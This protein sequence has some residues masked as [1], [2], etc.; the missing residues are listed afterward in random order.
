MG[1][2]N[3]KNV[4]GLFCKLFF[5][6]I[7]NERRAVCLVFKIDFNFGRYQFFPYVKCG[8][9]WS[10]TKLHT[11]SQIRVPKSQAYAR[12][13]IKGVIFVRLNPAH[14]SYRDRYTRNRMNELL[15]V[16]AQE[17]QIYSICAPLRCRKTLLSSKGSVTILA[18]RC[19]CTGTCWMSRHIHIHCQVLLPNMGEWI[20]YV[21]IA[22]LI[23]TSP[24][25]FA[26][27]YLRT[28]CRGKRD[29][30]MLLRTKIGKN[31][32]KMRQSKWQ[33]AYSMACHSYLRTK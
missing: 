27:V 14:E 13:Q 21:D 31:K 25:S 20:Q 19:R 6:A 5:R 33:Y 1:I 8:R 30:G 32:L 15:T 2:Q 18:G 22:M 23:A 28:Y 17:K 24:A 29:L 3:V 26:Y 12:K 16:N 9:W 7:F 10:K 4:F 11:S